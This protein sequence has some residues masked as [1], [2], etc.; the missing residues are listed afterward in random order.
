MIL[1]KTVVLHLH[2]HTK[3]CPVALFVVKTDLMIMANTTFFFSV[4]ERLI[5][6]YKNKERAEELQYRST[7]FQ[8]KGE[9]ETYADIFNGL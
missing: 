1:A 3:I 8:N 9:E 5:I 7:Y 2:Y 6:Q 4:K